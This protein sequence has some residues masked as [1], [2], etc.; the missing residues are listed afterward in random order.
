MDD[1]AFVRAARKCEALRRE[2][3]EQEQR[4]VQL[5]SEQSLR[6][7]FDVGLESKTRF[8]KRIIRDLREDIKKFD[9]LYNQARSNTNDCKVSFVL[10]LFDYAI[11]LSLT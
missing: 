4:L 5:E 9:P 7:N 6:K 10:V 2:L 8:C 3:V 1:I 11:F